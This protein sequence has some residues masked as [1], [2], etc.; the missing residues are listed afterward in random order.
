M[1]RPMRRYEAQPFHVGVPDLDVAFLLRRAAASFPEAPAVEDKTRGLRLDALIGQAERLAN[2]L[3]GLGIPAGGTVGVLLENRWEYVLV[4][5]ALALGRRVRVAFNA[6][7]HLEDFRYMA[8]DAQLSAVVHS[9]GFAAEAAALAEERGLVTIDVDDGFDALIARS[10]PTPVQ[11]GGSAEDPAWITYTSG[12]TGRPKGVTLSHRSIR[13]VALNLLLEL[14]PVVPGEQLVLTQA[15]S[16]GAGYFVLPFLMSGAGV[17]VVRRFDP[18]EI[19]AVGAR[20]HVHT[21]KVVPAMLPQLLDAADGAG[22]D[23]ATVVYG[24][25]PIAPAVLGRAL[26]RLGPVLVQIYG[27]SE[28][29][30]TLTCLHKQ[31]H[32][33]EGDE[34]FSAGRAWRS[35][36]VEVRDTDG[37]TV[38][39]GEAGEVHVRGSHMMSGYHGLPE[40]TSA[41][42]V[43]GWIRTGDMG[44]RDERGFVY[45]LG[46]RDEMINSGGYNVSPREVERVLNEHPA[47]QEVVVFGMPDERWGQAVTAAVCARGGASLTAAELSEFARPRLGFR[48]PKT[49][50]VLDE[51]PTNAYGKVDR[52]R[53]QAA[54]RGHGD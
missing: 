21:L 31:D 17:Y 2:A 29:P 22:L 11:R 48:A 24:A 18:E 30:V 49:I 13:E 50:N 9:A 33:G 15:L 10:D 5:A 51:I 37:S 41:A 20:S 4:D 23:Y 28:A 7:L 25:S 32:L 3:D 46:R 1:F 36:G 52:E 35:V 45:L 39:P 8:A 16:H 47:V 6:R 26:D 12:T 44:R 54:I 42:V 27:Q 19:M 43:D 14:G 34:R 40:A 53:L 38:G